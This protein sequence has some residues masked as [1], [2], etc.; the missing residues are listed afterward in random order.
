MPNKCKIEKV[1]RDIPVCKSLLF[2]KLQDDRS[3]EF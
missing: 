2:F 1:S 3:G